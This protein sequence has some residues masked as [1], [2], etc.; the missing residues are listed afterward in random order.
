MGDAKP[1]PPPPAGPAPAA[2]AVT[3]TK[4]RA[5]IVKLMQEDAKARITSALA[6]I[7]AL[8][9]KHEVEIEATTAVS[10]GPNGELRISAAWRLV[11][12]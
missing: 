2:A 5:D 12:R 11:A 10:L 6:E 3:T 9:A 8:C 1:V 7:D 4:S